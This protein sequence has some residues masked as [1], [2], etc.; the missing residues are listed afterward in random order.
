[1][2]FSAAV[3]F[4][5][6]TA[7]CS[8]VSAETNAGTASGLRRTEE[9][10]EDVAEVP[11]VM[12]SDVYLPATSRIVG[13]SQVQDVA[14]YPWFVQGSG[15][16]ASLI[17]ADMLLTAAHCEGFPFTN[18]VQLNS[19]KAFNVNANNMPAGA[20]QVQTQIQ[21]PHP[22][23]NSNS[24]DND[25]ML[26]KL[27]TAVNATVVTLNFD[28]GFP[29][30]NQELRVIGV[31]TTSEGGPTANFLRQVDVDYMST[32]DCKSYYG[33]NSINGNVMLCASGVGK[34]SCQGDSG[35]PIF[36]EDSRKQVG[37]V[38]WG[39]GCARPNFPGVYSRLSGA[40]EWIKEVV[41]GDSAA[42]SDYP[43][44]FCPTQT[45]PVPAPPTP[46]PPTPSPPALQ[47]SV[48][49]V[50]VKHDSYPTETGW[51]L[52][53]SSGTVLLRQ[54]FGSINTIDEIVSNTVSV[55]AGAYKFEIFDSWGDGISQSNNYQIKINGED[56][57]VNGSAFSNSAARSFV[58]G[59][60]YFIAIK[61]DRFPA[62]TAWRLESANGEVIIGV[63]AGIVT[64][65]FAYYEASIPLVPG[66]DYVLILEDTY[67]D[68]F[69]CNYG[70]GYIRVVSV[71][72]SNTSNLEEV[73]L[74]QETFEDTKTVSFS[75]PETREA[76]TRTGGDTVI[77][78]KRM[79][80]PSTAL[81]LCMDVPGVTFDVEA[82]GSKTCAWLFFNIVE[83]EYLCQFEDVA[84][85]CPGTCNICSSLGAP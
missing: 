56:T 5:V 84:V 22:D 20:I 79:K 65:S 14:T 19:L 13:G 12:H 52:K 7:A 55:P 64:R 42:K 76:A 6:A 38:S 48:V 15:C 68:G 2:K 54:N 67:R 39:Y 31:G 44:D 72:D 9:Q 53:D 36:D 78:N 83:F 73:L 25:F 10:P 27:K 34:D 29:L 60:E 80:R 63:G 61:Y 16:A 4:L 8:L 35:G 77:R 85:A 30:P 26:V 1:M 11:I 41:C 74:F 43:P 75:I 32:N 45:P 62:E 24:Q 46:A 82:I 50:I 69:C 17:A 33:Q 57:Y 28:D 71:T 18:K 21:T 81:P 23:Y 58:V 47:L 3:S 70:R 51:T 59:E 49:E 37:V 66:G 40:E